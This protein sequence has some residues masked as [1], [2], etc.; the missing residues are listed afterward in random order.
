MPYS[1]HCMNTNL[2]VELEDVALSLG[3]DREALARLGPEDKAGIHVN[4]A[5]QLLR[6]PVEQVQRAGRPHTKKSTAEDC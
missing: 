4:A 2:A 5:H 3:R 1:N 6:L